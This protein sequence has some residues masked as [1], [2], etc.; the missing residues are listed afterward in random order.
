MLRITTFGE[1]IVLRGQRRM[2]AVLQ[3]PRL[4]ALLILLAA[5]GAAGVSR[6]R[7][8]ALLSTGDDPSADDDAAR[9][10]WEQD[11]SQLREAL[12]A[13]HLSATGDALALDPEGATS[14]VVEFRDA[15]VAGQLE[16]AVRL[17]QARL[18]EGWRYR[19]APAFDRWL[20]MQREALASDAAAALERL[21][22]RAR[23]QGELLAAV[24][25][26]R[27]LAVQYPLNNRIAASLMEALV[28]AGDRE[29]ALQ[30]AQYLEALAGEQL[31]L[32]GDAQVLQL[33]SALRTSTRTGI[34]PTSAPQA[35]SATD[36]LRAM[37]A[38]LATRY[39]IVQEIGRGA[40]GVVLKAEDLRHARTVAIKVLHPDLASSLTLNRFSREIR[41][42]AALQHPNILPL[43][44]S[45]SAGGTLYYVVPFVDGGSLRDRLAREGPLSVREA[46]AIARQIARALA[47][48]HRRSVIHR[49]I[50]P[51]N[52]LLS[53]SDALLA[54]FGIAS[55]S[56]TTTTGGLTMTGHAVGTPAYMSP[57]Q[58]IPGEV[59]DGRSDIYSLACV[60]VEMLSGRRLDTQR[61]SGDVDPTP[62]LAD[63]ADVPPALIEALR[64]AL[65]HDPEARHASASE[66][67]GA[68]ENAERAL[69]QRTARNGFR[70]RWPRLSLMMIL[71]L[72][73]ISLAFTLERHHAGDEHGQVQRRAAEPIT[74]V[75]DQQ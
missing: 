5:H 26:W 65:R 60:L 73:F 41:I 51:E 46:L 38:E 39:G 68:L 59:L 7:A 37:R 21:A 1:L 71:L 74:A 13:E 42:V 50:K 32:P 22:E 69:H 17:H 27:Q 14:D 75:E 35:G 53:G 24:H 9:T 23:R 3:S 44:D 52:I 40:Y 34:V 58:A 72:L 28:A 67:G 33:A 29:G 36:L 20:V 62:A 43:F 30:H 66:F 31:D 70:M 64:A 57:E 47:E 61:W 4:R 16:R 45:G 56:D 25:W 18:V 11:V 6:G 19:S 10:Q 2:D 55:E 15:I 63:V 54:D 48:A 8:T 49:D 12:G